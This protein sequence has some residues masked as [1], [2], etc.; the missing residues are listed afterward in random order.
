MKASLVWSESPIKTTQRVRDRVWQ[1]ETVDVR[2]QNF[3]SAIVRQVE[4]G[5]CHGEM[6]VVDSTSGQSLTTCYWSVTVSLPLNTISWYINV[7]M[8][9]GL[10]VSS[11]YI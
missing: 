7:E 6:Y 2:N 4:Q 9:Q 3:D 1:E 8:E 5:S 11:E 10:I